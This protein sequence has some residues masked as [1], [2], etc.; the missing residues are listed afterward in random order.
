MLNSVRIHNSWRSTAVVI[1][2][3]WLEHLCTQQHHGCE[4]M[5]G[6]KV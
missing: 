4:L 6:V 1:Y 5:V 2:R 3:N